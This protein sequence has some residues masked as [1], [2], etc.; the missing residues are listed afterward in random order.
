M[1]LSSREQKQSFN[2]NDCKSFSAFKKTCFEFGDGDYLVLFSKFM[3]SC[4]HLV[5]L[6]HT[7]FFW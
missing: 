7:L 4:T 6:D 1:F 2:K 5:G 3:F